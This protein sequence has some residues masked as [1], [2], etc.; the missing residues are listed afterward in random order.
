MK[1]LPRDVNSTDSSAGLKFPGAFFR[2]FRNFLKLP[3][4]HDAFIILPF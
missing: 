2:Y 1:N 4:T 3:A